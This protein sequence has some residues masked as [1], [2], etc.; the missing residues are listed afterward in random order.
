ML[1]PNYSYPNTA[2]KTIYGFS[3]I[4]VIALMFVSCETDK[5]SN[6]IDKL[7]VEYLTNPEGID[8]EKPRLS[9]Q[10]SSNERGFKQQAYR[11]IVSS[12]LDLLKKDSGDIWDSGKVPS[13]ETV[14]IPYGGSELKS[15][16]EYFW[17]VMIWDGKGS[18]LSW[19]NPAKWSMGLLLPYD[20]KAKWIGL[21]KA[22][23]LKFHTRLPARYLRKEIPV[24]KNITRA[25]AYVCGQGLFEWYINGSKI[26]DQVLVP[27][28]SEF[29]K[30]SYYLTFDVT[31]K[32]KKGDNAFGV[33]LGNGRY[34][35]PRHT[36]DQPKYGF[37]KLM[38]QLSIE[39]S[40]GSSEMVIS[41]DTWKITANGPIVAN[42]EFDGEEYDATKEMPGWNKPGFDDSAWQKAEYVSAASPRL[43]AQPCPSIAVMETIKPVSVKEISPGVFIFDM[44]QNMVGWTKLNV[45]GKRG[46]KVKMRFAEILNDDGSLY[47]ANI[48]SAKVTD[49][50]TLK[51]EGNETFEPVFTYHG[52]RYVEVTGFPG[53]PNLSAI[54]GKVV[55][56]RMETTGNFETSNPVIN[57]IYKN[58][59]WGIRG[60]YRSIPTD[61]PQRDERQ[62]WLGDRATGSKGESFVFNNAS[63]YAKWMQDI[64]DS[65]REDGCVPDVA[66]TYWA[67]YNGD[68]TWPAAYLIISGML[69]DQFGDKKPIETHYVSFRK[70]IDFIKNN[71]MKDGIVTVDTYGDWCMPPERQELIH[72]EDPS[73][74][75]DGAILSTTY[76]YHMLS[77]MKQYAK[78]LGRNNDIAEYQQLA[79]TI[80]NAYNSKYFNPETN[81]YGNNTATA[82]LLSLAYG[83]V[84]EDKKHDVFKNIVDKTMNDFK[85]HISCGLIGAQWIMRILTEYGMPDIAYKLTTNKT[86]PSWGYMVENNATTIWELWNGN[87]ADPSMNSANHVML[88]GDLLIWYYESLAGI[89]SDPANPG[90]KRVIMKPVPVDGLDY[91]NAS[92]NSI[93]GPIKSEWK[94]NNGKFEWNISIPANSSAVVLIP[95]QS[96]E[97]ITESGKKLSESEGLTVMGRTD[98][99]YT[100]VTVGSGSY[101]FVSN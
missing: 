89:K 71:T 40:D 21:D 27:A 83:L 34:F 35:D 3:L 2:M 23:S 77:L 33:I 69:Y 32:L 20:W 26:G 73:R 82:N 63:M 70:W 65:Q 1:Q 36:G 42:N 5:K 100:L 85:G 81:G 52:F 30:R 76:F 66:P 4:F 51:G 57:A 43:D 25:T 12:S 60:N 68:V 75:T 80:Y 11:I 22:D 99:G 53:T 74:K 64:H 87:T 47:L 88:L 61:C 95:S 90:F 31:G 94:K 45:K 6:P 92:Y 46:D 19:S 41:D 86:Y 29:S 101:S 91:V 55:Y 48:R 44:G 49:I 62:G 79:D 7:T 97:N 72:S 50:Y 37:P 9:W 39:Y 13:N 14:N 54:E 78:L 10:L 93:R 28:L 18:E 24:S 15:G 84:P 67:I 98:D 17:K 59:Y 58:A 96:T 16:R 38:F 56:D 8:T